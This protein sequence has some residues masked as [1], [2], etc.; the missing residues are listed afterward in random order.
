MRRSAACIACHLF[1][2]GQRHLEVM[3]AKRIQRIHDGIRQGRQRPA[4]ALLSHALRTEHIQLGRQRIVADMHVANHAGPR[5]EVIHE[6]AGEELTGAGIIHALLAR[7]IPF[8][9]LALL[10]QRPKTGIEVRDQ[11]GRVFEADV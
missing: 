9:P 11:I 2:R 10:R 8:P 7:R 4:A 1:F 5:H 3:D 6:A